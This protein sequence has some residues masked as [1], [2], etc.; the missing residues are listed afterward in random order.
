[1]R[2]SIYLLPVIALLCAC[3]TPRAALK[4]GFDFS[5]I[6]VVRV[7]EFTAAPNQANSGAVIANEFVRQLLAMGYIVKTSEN[8][9]SADAVLMG[10]V[11]EFQPNRRYLIQQQPAGGRN[12]TVVVNPPIELGGTSTY[13]LGTAFGLG[14]NSKI[15][16]SNATIGVTAYLR[17]N[18][19]GDVVWSNTYSYEGLD[20][21]SAMEGTVRYL[22]HSW[23]AKQQ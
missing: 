23:P 16:V 4:P 5:R 8:D 1:M 20:L 21:N 15:V 3:A 13:D 19:S 2:K 22:V 17:D 14:E 9:G 18:A 7:G 6:K 10:S 12:R 11:T